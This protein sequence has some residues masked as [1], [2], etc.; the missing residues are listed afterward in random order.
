VSS[1]LLVS[2]IAMSGA[3]AAL[4]AIGNAKITKN[5]C[6]LILTIIVCYITLTGCG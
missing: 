2:K 1:Y 6:L 5:A 3:I 4:V